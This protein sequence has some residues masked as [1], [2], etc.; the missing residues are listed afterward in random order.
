MN[1]YNNLDPSLFHRHDAHT[2]DLSQEYPRQV[3]QEMIQ[4]YSTFHQPPR[5]ESLPRR[6]I[7][8]REQA[9]R[10]LNA[11]TDES[12]KSLYPSSPSRSASLSPSHSY[13]SRVPVSGKSQPLE[14]SRKQ[15]NRSPRTQASTR[16]PISV[17]YCEWHDSG[18]ALHSRPT[19]FSTTPDAY[20]GFRGWK[21]LCKGLS[22]HWRTSTY[23]SAYHCRASRRQHSYD[24]AAGV[25][26]AL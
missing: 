4:N 8:I 13:P 3:P 25:S 1:S 12:N 14:A 24:A 26:E 7:E 15:L 20:D 18:P 17:I 22:I 2:N 6:H 10:I 23:L 19:E 5:A 16:F 9:S 11:Q 21:W